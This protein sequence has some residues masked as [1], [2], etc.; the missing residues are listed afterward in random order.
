MATMIKIVNDPVILF[1]ILIGAATVIGFFLVQIYLDNRSYKTDIKEMHD[2]KISH[3]TNAVNWI[4]VIVE[5]QTRISALEKNEHPATSN[6]Y[7]EAD[8]LRDQFDTKRWVEDNFQKK[9]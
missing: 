7:T 4:N 2:W 9:E 3:E 1:K 6:R 5:N 8:A